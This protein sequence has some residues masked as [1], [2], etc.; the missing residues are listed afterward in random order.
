[1]DSNEASP[2]PHA[3]TS[4]VTTGADAPASAADERTAQPIRPGITSMQKRVLAG[5]S[6]GQFIEFYD[7]ALYGLSAV[8]LST[9]FFPPETFG[10]WEIRETVRKLYVM[11]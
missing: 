5:G 3:R 9:L 1:M 4:T 8:V 11:V 6:V 2:P 7:F 10:V